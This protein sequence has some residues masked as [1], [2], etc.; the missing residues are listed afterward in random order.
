MNTRAD[1][2]APTKCKMIP[3]FNLCVGCSPHSVG[4]LHESLW[5]ELVGVFINISICMHRAHTTDKNGILGD[6]IVVYNDIFRSHMRNT[7]VCNRT[8]SYD[9]LLYADRI[10]K[11]FAIFMERR[12]SP[13][14]ILG[15]PSIKFFNNLVL[16]IWFLREDGKGPVKR[17]SYGICASS[18]QIGY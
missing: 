5:Y 14:W 17:N 9:F 4:I 3:V 7:K 16:Y 8:E 15:F 11:F 13:R 18:K 12:H 1:S 10:G 6:K 2:S